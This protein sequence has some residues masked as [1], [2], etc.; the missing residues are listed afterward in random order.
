MSK[1]PNEITLPVLIRNFKFASNLNIISK[2]LIGHEGNTIDVTFK[3]RRNKRTNNQNAYYWKVIVIIFQNC[4]LEEW[5]E[6]WTKQ[7]THE[8]LKY[9][10]NFEEKVI[11]DTGEI[12]RVVLSTTENDTVQQEIFHK[13]CRTLCLD[14]FNTEIPEPDKSLKIDFNGR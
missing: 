5:G 4:I 1:S 7:K 11:E 14:F 9:N 3:K 8:F 2:I 6:V 12:I 10:C 13:K